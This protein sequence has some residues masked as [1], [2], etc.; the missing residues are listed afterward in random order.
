M[1]RRLTFVQSMC[2]AS[3]AVGWARCR[4]VPDGNMVDIVNGKLNYLQVL[5][6]NMIL[7]QPR[8]HLR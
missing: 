5:F 6:R 2:L 4:S 7:V 8:Y 3:L 1:L